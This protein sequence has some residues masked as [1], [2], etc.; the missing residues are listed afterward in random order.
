MY[1]PTK[2]H[3]ELT[4]KQQRFID[5]YLVDL[6]ATRAA[7]EA[8]YS[9]RTA[10][11]QGSRLLRNV[12]VTALIEQTQRALAERSEISQEMV[13]Q[14]LARIAFNDMTNVAEWGPEGV[15]VKASS[16]LPEMVRRCIAEVTQTVTA[17]GGSTV[18]VKLHD[19]LA[20]LQLLG[21]H[22]GMFDNRSQALS[23]GKIEITI[24]RREDGDARD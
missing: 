22:L 20:A 14:E 12:E 1:E 3:R 7:I 15:T 18:R 11:V 17:A 10:F 8:G 9:K 21:K 5:E 19:K 13:V 2:N 6:N 4:P 23:P 16:E 24:R